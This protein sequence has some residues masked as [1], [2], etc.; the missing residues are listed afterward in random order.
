[1]WPSWVP[2]TVS[3]TRLQTK[4]LMDLRLLLW[5]GVGDPL[6]IHWHGSKD[7]SDPNW[8]LA[9]DISSLPYGGFHRTTQNMVVCF[10]KSRG[11]KSRTRTDDFMSLK[12]ETIS[13]HLYEFC[14]FLEMNGRQQYRLH[15]GFQEAGITGTHLRGCVPRVSTSRITKRPSE[16]LTLIDKM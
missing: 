6:K 9:I 16:I 2:L 13:H 4:Y 8:L 11:F 10:L 1:M 14:F 5:L 3:L 12:V 15:K 7:T